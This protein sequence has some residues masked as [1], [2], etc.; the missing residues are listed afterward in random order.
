M[1]SQ[2]SEVAERKSPAVATPVTL[3]LR[4]GPL[5][6]AIRLFGAVVLGLGVSSFIQTGVGHFGR[7][8]EVRSPTMW[9]LTVIVAILLVDL[10]VRFLPFPRVVRGVIL[11][12]VVIAV[13]VTAA[14]RAASPGPLWGPPL[15]SLVWWID[16]ADLSFSTASLVLS[17]PIGTPGCEK[18]AWAELYVMLRGGRRPAGRWCVGGLHVVDNWEIARRLRRAQA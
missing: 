10:I 4:T 12:A 17:I 9:V 5:G 3:G 2:R 14:I 11:A 13:I 6:R 1:S 15:S 7:A 16:V 18:V 8:S